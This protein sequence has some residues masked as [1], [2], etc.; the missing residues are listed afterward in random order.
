[1]HRLWM[2]I[3]CV[4]GGG[5]GPSGGCPDPAY[6]GEVQGAAAVHSVPVY[7]SWGSSCD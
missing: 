5:S 1:M 6:S 3:L 2:V 7:G 4:V